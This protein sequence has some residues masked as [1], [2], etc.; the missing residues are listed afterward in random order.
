MTPAEDSRYQEQPRPTHVQLLEMEVDT[1]YNFVQRLFRGWFPPQEPQSHPGHLVRRIDPDLYEVVPREFVAQ[2]HRDQEELIQIKKFLKEMTEKHDKLGEN[3]QALNSQLDKLRDTKAAL[4]EKTGECSKIRERW[5][6]AIG[7][8]SELKSSN[9]AFVVDDSEMTGNWKALQYTIKNFARLYFRRAI[10]PQKLSERQVELLQAVSPLYQEFLVNEAHV[11]VLFQ[12]L[13]WEVISVA[14]L[15]NPTMVW[16]KDISKATRKLLR[17][18]KPSST[19]DY[20]AWRAQTAQLIQVGNGTNDEL[21]D[22]WEKT[23]HEFIVQFISDNVL[24]SDRNA[25]IIYR[26]VKGIV[27]KAIN[28]AVIFNQS[29]CNYKIQVVDHGRIFNSSTMEYYDEQCDAANVDLMIS[30]ALLKREAG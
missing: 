6:A 17:Y 23:L 18:I 7:E 26:Q 1:H 4:D 24:R 22:Y 2:A 9:C 30:P 3:C 13:V 21:K 10:Q 25:E 28:L 12:S 16:G 27:G 15:Q 29:R 19:E 5:Q 20:H 11:H 8:L 14:L